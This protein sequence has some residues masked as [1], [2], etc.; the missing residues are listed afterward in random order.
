[1][2]VPRIRYEFGTRRVG[3]SPPIADAGPNQLNIAPGT[4]TLNGSG[5]YDPLGLALTYQWTQIAGPTVRDHQSDWRRRQ[6]PRRMGQTYSF[7]LTVKNT[8]GL[9]GFG[10]HHRQYQHSRR[11]CRSRSSSPTPPASSRARAPL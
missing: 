2:D 5:S 4:I 3:S 6:L 10:Q 9:I 1:M 11:R 8:D 7:R